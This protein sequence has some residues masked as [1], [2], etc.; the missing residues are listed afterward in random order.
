MVRFALV[1]AV[2][3]VGWPSPA[4][5]QFCRPVIA[6]GYSH[7]FGWGRIWVVPP[8]VIVVRPV[9]VPRPR[10]DYPFD[11]EPEP[12]RE[13]PAERAAAEA[14]VNAAVERGDLLVIKPGK[15]VGPRIPDPPAWVNDRPPV[16]AKPP[17]TLDPPKPPADPKAL[18]AFRITAGRVAFAAGEYGRAADRFRAAAPTDPLAYFLLAQAHTA[19]GE[20]TEAVAAIR[21]G[22]RKRPDW[23]RSRFNIAE[24]YGD[25]RQPLADHLTALR[26]AATARAVDPAARFLYGYHLWFAGERAAAAKVFRALSPLVRDNAAIERFL[27]EAEGKDL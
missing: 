5:A 7:G 19:R 3:A 13:D 11:R 18:A 12:V 14:R 22:M 23:P 24:V 4:A 9:A 8:P 17:V 20:Y 25:R 27:Q 15:P 16:G 6:V 10:F 2:V 1:V 26:A 21:D